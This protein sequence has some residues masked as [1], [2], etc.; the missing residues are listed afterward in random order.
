MMAKRENNQN[1]CCIIAEAGVNHNGS[2]EMAR[3]LIDVAAGAGADAVK[4]QTFK[5]EK[6]I[7]KHA[8]KAEY[9]KKTTAK[10]ESQLNMVRKLELN[11]EA[12]RILIEHC[13]SRKIQ[14]LSTPFDFDSIDLLA[15]TFKLPCLKIPSG[16]ITNGPYLLKAARTGKNVIL[17]TGMS[18]L[19]EVEEALGVLAFGYAGTRNNPSRDAF[20][21]AW[22]S[23][24]G[25]QLLKERVILL[26]C[27]TEYPAPFAEANLRAM[28]TLRVAFHLPV[29]L[30]DHTP[31]ITVPIAAVA[32]GA[33]VIEKHFTLDK[34]LPGPDHKA[35]LDPDELKA[36]IVSIRQVEEALGHGLK[37]PSPSE[38][39][40]RDIARK[41]LVA[42]CI[43]KKGELF[44]E[45]NIAI[46]RPG[47]GLSPLSY[48][49]LINRKAE[50]AYTPDEIISE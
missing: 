48:W 26:H 14:F 45:T 18:T 22:C 32:M 5:A 29:G 28:E 2:I 38:W 6:V 20:S 49:N 13:R 44:D 36:M 39:K 21:E 37:L 24:E 42:G 16:E 30:S 1:L 4:F 50:K 31:G 27:T 23:R 3:Q 34:N 43:I 9:Q 11:E 15:E 8:P 46:K 10:A 25:Q 47:N 17:S 35:S 33:V 19:G 12:H 7:S 41:S 40:N